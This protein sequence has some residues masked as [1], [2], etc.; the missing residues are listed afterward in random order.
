MVST[1][2]DTR[3]LLVDDEVGKGKTIMGVQEIV[4]P[5]YHHKRYVVIDE[6][7]NLVIPVVRY[8][9]Y[10]DTIGR[11][12]N[13]LRSYAQSLSLYFTYLAQQDLDYQEV[14]L[15]DLGGFVLWLKNPS[16]S[17]K[18][19]PVQPVT[20]ARTN[21]TINNCIAAVAGFYDYLWRQDD[22]AAD[23]NEKTRTHLPA[24]ARSY[25]SFLHHLAK[26]KLVEKNLLKQRVPRRR[27]PK[28]LS[29]EQIE[30]LV[31]AC[32]NPRDHLLLTL[33]YE[34]SLRVGECLALWIED[35]DVDGR[36]IHVRD[37]GPLANDAEIKTPASCRSVDVSDEL[38]NQILD[39]LIVVHTDDVTTNHLFIK[40]RG[41]HAGQPLEYA[42]INDL[43]QSVSELGT[44]GTERSQARQKE[45]DRSDLD[46]G[47]RAFRQALIIAS[48][49]PEADQP[50]KG[51]FDLP[52]VTLDLKA[53]FGFGQLDGFAIDEHP[54][55]VGIVVGFGH[56]LGLPTQLLLDPIDQG[57]GIALI[58]EEMTQAWK[59]A[60]Q[61]LQEQRR[62]PTINQTGRMDL[63]GQHQSL[64]V[65]Q[66]VPL[67]TPDFFSP[68]RSRV[69]CLARDWF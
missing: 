46:E 60:C 22:L 8:L 57:S 14:M 52:S 54:L 3:R 55:L 47:L 51:A 42:D 39:Y 12:R 4:T 45:P 43:F 15:D 36:K 7:G 11:A 5:Q 35:V 63:D 10:L 26:G 44:Q 23:L 17:L 65:D 27:Q 50:A 24:R 29:K 41:A 30:M 20:Q 61:V 25:K 18:V 9:K 58:G 21:T 32:E 16:R 53:A 28:T 56:N 6:D 2:Y 64:R 19:L 38:I 37:R 33:L 66:N 1:V 69:G 48:Q 40:L 68:R 62:S 34:S 59:T 31:N 13:T 49:T 67:A